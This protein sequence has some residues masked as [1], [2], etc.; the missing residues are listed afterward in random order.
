MNCIPWRIVMNNDNRIDVY[1][2]NLSKQSCVDF[3][4]IYNFYEPNTRLVG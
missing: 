4:I 2:L 1:T 3:I